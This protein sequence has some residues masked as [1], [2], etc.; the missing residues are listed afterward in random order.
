[1]Q[2]KQEIFMKKMKTLLITLALGAL[3]LST[4]ADVT[5]VL[6]LTVVG[7]VQQPAVTTTNVG[8]GITNSVALFTNVVLTTSALLKEIATDQSLTLPVGAKLGLISGQFVVLY[9]NNTVFANVTVMTFSV[10]T[11]IGRTVI[12]QTKTVET[13]KSQTLQ[14]ATITYSGASLTFTVNVL[15]AN[16]G[17]AGDNYVSGKQTN[18]IGGGYGF[19]YGTVGGAPMLAK[20]FLG[21]GGSGAYVGT[22]P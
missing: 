12:T 21:G 20:A 1:M 16:T 15:S 22:L 9:P 18:I 8:A 14:V 19:G 6:T 7:A 5:N 2:S 4:R 11:P 10:G 3:A 13:K 17:T